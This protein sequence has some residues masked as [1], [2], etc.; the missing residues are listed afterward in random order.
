M[1]KGTTINLLMINTIKNEDIK[2]AVKPCYK[3]KTELEN[4][5]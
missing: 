5:I 4:K 1:K 2:I 3:K